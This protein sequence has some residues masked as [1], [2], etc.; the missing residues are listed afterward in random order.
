MVERTEAQRLLDG[1]ARIERSV[2]V[3]EH[4]LHAAP[5]VA[6]GQLGADLA[7]V[8]RDLAAVVWRQVHEHARGRG[9]AAA[10]LADHAKRLA[11]AHVEG[12]VV[13]RAHVTAV[14]RPGGTQGKVLVQA[15][16]AQ[17]ALARASDIGKGGRML[18]GGCP[19]HERCCRSVG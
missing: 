13:D 19:W 12:D 11:L 16:H 4:H 14:Q 7:A 5:E 9:L 1:H 6:H 2:A 15:A 10:G 17:Q 18:I 8:E 3:L